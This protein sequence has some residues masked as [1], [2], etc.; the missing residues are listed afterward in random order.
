MFISN[1]KKRYRLLF[2]IFTLIISLSIFYIFYNESKESSSVIDSGSMPIIIID[3]NGQKIE[4]NKEKEETKVG[5]RTIGI[6][7]ESSKYNVKLSLYENRN[8]KDIFENKDVKPTVTTDAVINTRGQSS[9]NYDKKQY[10]IR[11]VKEGNSKNPLEILGMA[12][13]DKWVLNGMYSDKSLLRNYIAYK[14]GRQTMEYSPD[15]RFVE[16]YLNEEYIGIYLLVEKIERDENR[17]AISKNDEKYR[18]IS[19]II[20]RD[21]TKVGD[22]ILEN[23]W[24]KFEDEYSLVSKD[25]LKMKSV[26]TTTYPSKENMTEEDKQKITKYINDFEYTLR[27]NRFT[28]KKEGYIQYI[29]ADSF[30]NYAI[31]NEIA[32]NIDGGEVSA[33]FYK[34]LGEKMKAGPLWDFDQSMS[35]TGIPDIDSPTGLKMVNTI[36]FERLFQDEYFANRYK[37]NYKK[38]RSTLWTDS[39]VNKLIDEAILEL[40]PAVERNIDKWYENYTVEDYY[41]ETEEVRKFLIERLNWM[42]KNINSIKRIKENVTN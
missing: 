15:T 20:S 2:L 24:D 5:D 7:Q 36:W 26:F 11:F 23:D 35:N 19:F 21:K 8:Y 18:D 14:M 13:H 10:T 1:R 12:G 3:T 30:I 9:L 42:D 34:E 38:Y 27:S 28:D 6:Y 41:N 37:I 4:S 40:S 22:I 39:N 25:T 31:I 17:V 33:Y 29:D 32:K 16:V